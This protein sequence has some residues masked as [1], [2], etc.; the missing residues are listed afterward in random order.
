VSPIEK[1]Q[2]FPLLVTFKGEPKGEPPSATFSPQKWKS[3]F[4]EKSHYP[5]Q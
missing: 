4:G 5:V 3:L 2:T 1:S